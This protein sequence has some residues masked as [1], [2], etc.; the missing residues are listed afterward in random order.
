MPERF[1]FDVENGRDTIRDEEGVEAGSLDEALT[2]ARSVIAEMA[3]E[4]SAADPG[5]SWT[6]V[7]RD[8]SGLALCRL[9]IRR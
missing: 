7:V 2:E 1:Y 4:V 3:D 8:A 9:P 5:R 6:L